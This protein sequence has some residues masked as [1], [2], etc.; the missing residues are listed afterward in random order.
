MLVVLSSKEK[1]DAFRRF[2]TAAPVGEG[3]NLE[4]DDS[5]PHSRRVAS[6][7]R[8]VRCPLTLV[9]SRSRLGLD[10]GAGASMLGL[11]LVARGSY[12][13]LAP[14]KAHRHRRPRRLLRPE[15]RA[16]PERTL[17]ALQ[18]RQLF[19]R[20]STTTF[21]AFAPQHRRERAASKAR[22]ASTCHSSQKSSSPG[23]L[24]ACSTQLTHRASSMGSFSWM[25]A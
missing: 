2:G 3:S 6:D 7:A 10:A 13:T 1:E 22:H 8:A 24:E 9:G 25:W 12:L 19:A 4:V 16:P 20:A 18:A 5:A 21:V 23:R 14:L 11:S 17:F 15:P